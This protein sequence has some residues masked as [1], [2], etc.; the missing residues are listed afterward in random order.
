MDGYIYSMLMIR[1][2]TVI[3]G[4]SNGNLIIVKIKEGGDIEKVEIKGEGSVFEMCSIGENIGVASGESCKVDIYDINT[5]HKT[6]SLE[7]PN[8]TTSISVIG[9][10]HLVTGCEDGYARI[11]NLRTFNLSEKRE[12]AG[13]TGIVQVVGLSDERIAISAYELPHIWIWNWKGDGGVKCIKNAGID[14][15]LGSRTKNKAASI[16]EIRPGLLAFGVKDN[17]GM[18]RVWNLGKDKEEGAFKANQRRIAVIRKYGKDKFMAGTYGNIVVFDLS[19]WA[20]LQVIDTQGQAWDF[21]CLSHILK[22][23]VLFLPYIYM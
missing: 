18:I 16:S 19:N 9:T 4:L 6:I 12:I 2:N 5:I 8:I 3:V 21:A 22:I 7:H 23:P 11:W 10:E 15:Q 14:A 20:T 17:Y 1:D 13:G